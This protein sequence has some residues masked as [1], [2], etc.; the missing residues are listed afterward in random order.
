LF[1]SEVVRGALEIDGGVPKAVVIGCGPI[2]RFAALLPVANGS[3]LEAQFQCLADSS[4]VIHDGQ[5]V[6]KAVSHWSTPE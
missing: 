3:F 1:V 6:P 4:A 5:H 2:D